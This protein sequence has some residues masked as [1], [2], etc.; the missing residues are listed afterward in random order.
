MLNTEFLD[1]LPSLLEPQVG[2]G[3]IR[4]SSKLLLWNKPTQ[5]LR[6]SNSNHFSHCFYGLGIQERLLGN[7]DSG[8][9][10]HLQLQWLELEQ[11]EGR[12]LGTGQA[13]SSLCFSFRMCGL[14]WTSSQN[15]ASGWYF[16]MVI[17]G[18]PPCVACTFQ[19]TSCKLCCLL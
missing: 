10:M 1:Q 13:G 7:S 2:N 11:Q 15:V 12:T 3:G 4:N 9:L 16:Y 5:N 6:G 19:Q 14:V 18:L 17:Q 8:L